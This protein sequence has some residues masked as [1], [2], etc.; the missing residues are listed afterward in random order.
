MTSSICRSFVALIFC[1]SLPGSLGCSRSNPASPISPG[2]GGGSRSTAAASGDA[3]VTQAAVTTGASIT[4]SV[5]TDVST[6]NSFRALSAGFIVRIVGTSIEAIVET[7][8]Y[9]ELHDVPEGNVELQFIG[10]GVDATVSVEA[11]K[12]FERI[13]LKVTVSGGRATIETGQRVTSDSKVELDGKITSMD[14]GSSSFHV[15][16]AVITVTSGTAI[17]RGTQTVQL[18][19]LHVGDAVHVKGSRDGAIVRAEQIDA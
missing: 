15:G 4:G 17:H 10:P 6:T 3:P 5:S 1:V 13:D 11:V 16:D 14:T 2:R 12:T 18:S 7:S 9:F 19:D 8:G